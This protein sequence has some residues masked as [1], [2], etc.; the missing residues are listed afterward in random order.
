MKIRLQKQFTRDFSL[1]IS[2]WWR[3]EMNER[4]QK[5]LGVGFKDYIA[6]NDGLSSTYYAREKDEQLFHDAVINLARRRPEFLRRL[7]LTCLKDGLVTRRFIKSIQRR[8]RLSPELLQK[9]L[10]RHQLLYPGLRI[11]L[12]LPASWRAEVD[13]IRSAR[14]LIPLGLK[15]R[16][17]T[18]GIFEEV[19]MLLRRQ[20]ERL[21][22]DHGRSKT[23]AKYLRLKELIQLT[24]GHTIDWPALPKRQQGFL[25][26]K[27]D[28]RPTRQGLTELR[29]AGYLVDSEKITGG[30]VTGQVAYPGQAVGIVRH[31]HTVE[32]MR[33]FKRGEILVSPMTI[34]AFLP[35][36]R[37]AK[38]IVTDEGGITC[39]AAIVARE[40]KIPCVI[41]TKVATKVFKAGDRVEVDATRGIVRKLS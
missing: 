4:F 13:A 9:L 24:E 2:E 22:L 41:G 23:D 20:G 18:D 1:A 37:M 39:H 33:S 34:P 3:R 29:R 40:L 21:L 31:I 7:L 38:A 12:R 8:R 28:V 30:I 35:A 36:M 26:L 19:D 15:V 14:S 25:Y 11:S 17:G 5:V 10:D 27:G 32:Q 6:V 16:K